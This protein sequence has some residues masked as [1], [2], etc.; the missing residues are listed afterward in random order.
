MNARARD[1]L[2][3]WRHG[4]VMGA[5]LAC[6]VVSLQAPCGAAEIAL[7]GQWRAAQSADAP[8]PPDAAAA[9][10]QSFAPAR[11][12][13]IAPAGGQ[14]W[15][16]LRAQDGAWPAAPWVLSVF[17]AGLQQLTLHDARG[18]ILAQAQLGRYEGRVWPGH[19]R[20][21]FLFDGEPG[22]GATLRL[23]VD[24]RHVI[25]G[26]LRFSAES[27]PD[28]L[29]SDARWL[30]LASASLGIMLAMALIALVFAQR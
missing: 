6:L 13:R 11:F 5:L 19:G 26:A 10:W 4:L 29:R 1:W 9:Q 27:A 22:P 17:N 30:A 20:V 3:G 12:T 18:Q 21:A 14:A 24:S 23:H 25:A 7:Q 15:I 8:A 16:E 2:H 28:F